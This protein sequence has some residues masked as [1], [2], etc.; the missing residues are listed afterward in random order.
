MPA[1]SPTIARDRD[2]RFPA[3]IY[4]RMADLGPLGSGIPAAQGGAGK[5]TPACAIALAGLARGPV[6]ATPATD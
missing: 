4:T 5:D 3:G 6:G 2:E 1:R